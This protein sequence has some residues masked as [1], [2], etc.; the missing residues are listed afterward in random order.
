MSLIWLYLRLAFLAVYVYLFPDDT[1]YESIFQE[2]AP[3]YPWML[4]HSDAIVKWILQPDEGGEC[5]GEPFAECTARNYPKRRSRLI[6]CLSELMR[7][8]ATDLNG[9]AQ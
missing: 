7:R 1:E 5:S 3:Y 2:E 4:N 8:G 9:A 6:R